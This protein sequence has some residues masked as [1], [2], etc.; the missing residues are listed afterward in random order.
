[1]L[2]AIL[3]PPFS[4]PNYNTL[5]SKKASEI[6]EIFKELSSQWFWCYEIFRSA[7]DKLVYYFGENLSTK[8]IGII[9]NSIIINLIK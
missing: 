6:S 2:A 9:I 8:L 4:T 5:E 1:M 7:D 3:T